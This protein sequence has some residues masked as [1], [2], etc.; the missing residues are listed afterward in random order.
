MLSE[1]KSILKVFLEQIEQEGLALAGLSKAGHACLSDIAAQMEERVTSDVFVQ[2]R[3][4]KFAHEIA[5]LVKQLG[6]LIRDVCFRLYRDKQFIQ[7]GVLTQVDSINLVQETK[8]IIRLATAEALNGLNELA[9]ESHID[10]ELLKRWRHFDSPMSTIQGQIKSLADQV[11]A[12]PEKENL[13]NQIRVD[14]SS[15]SSV[16]SR[17]LMLMDQALDEL[18]HRL[19]EQIERMREVADDASN[20]DLGAIALGLER[21]NESLEGAKISAQ[22]LDPDYNLP[23]LTQMPIKIE[24]GNLLVK[25]LNFRQGVR[26]W[27]EAE[28]NPAAVRVLKEYTRLLDRGIVTILNS[29]NSIQMIL[30][31][32]HESNSD[33]VDAKLPSETLDDYLKEMV[34]VRHEISSSIQD[35]SSQLAS[36]LLISNLFDEKFQFLDTAALSLSTYRQSR[37]QWFARIPINRIRTQLIDLWRKRPQGRLH[38]DTGLS[39]VI[40]F[41]E[42]HTHEE[43]HHEGHELFLKKG[44]LGQSFFVDRGGFDELLRKTLQ[45]W[46]NGYRGSVLIYGKRLSGRTALVRSLHHL[47]LPH[48]LIDLRQN[49]EINLEGRKMTTTADLDEALSFINKHTITHQVIVVIDDL[50]L[51]RSEHHTFFEN[52]QALMA[53]VNKY[54]RRLFF[55][56]VTNH[57]MKNQMDTHFNFSQQF[58]EAFCTDQMSAEEITRAILIRD[59]AILENGR[60]KNREE[61]EKRKKRKARI[62]GRSTDYN[63]GSALIE[64]CRLADQDPEQWRSGDVLNR[65]INRYWTLLVHIMKYRTASEQELSKFVGPEKMREINQGIQ[66]LLGCKLLFRDAHGK[67]TINEHILYILENQMMTNSYRSLSAN[68]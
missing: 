60:L 64:W 35:I 40:D 13:L 37:D 44:Y 20:Q 2:Y 66:F 50:E 46:Q 63:I 59:G 3:T 38:K 14:I 65:L 5:P 19:N 54:S 29:R 25:E 30:I 22:I 1:V 8:R 11:V 24:N 18:I 17:R 15:F 42:E 56:V 32:Q 16:T 7:D 43:S 27:I 61:E 33:A 48:L 23:G 53:D 12:F 31:N 28:I 68:V 41:I 62:I 39:G 4:S 67:L 9:K 45:K 47:D 58:V 34:K 51:W 10:E 55:I 6:I 52:V 36:K 49:S 57:W 26:S 21:F